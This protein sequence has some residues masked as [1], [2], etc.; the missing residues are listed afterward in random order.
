[1]ST[2]MHRFLVVVDATS[3]DAAERLLRDCV[4]SS[5]GA[6]VIDIADWPEPVLRPADTKAEVD[7]LLGEER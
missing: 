1:M 5:D 3:K 2:E 7:A 6:W 4:K